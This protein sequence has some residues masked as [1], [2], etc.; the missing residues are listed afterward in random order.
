[1]HHAGAGKEYSNT[2]KPACSNPFYWGVIVH[3]GAIYTT[4]LKISE[5]FGCWGFDLWKH[6][7][8]ARTCLRIRKRKDSIIWGSLKNMPPCCCCWR[9]CW[10]SLWPGALGANDVA[11]AMGASVGAR[12]I[13][14]RQAI[15]IAVIFEFAG[16]YLAGGEVTSTIREGLIDSTK[17]SDQPELL[18]LGCYRLYSLQ[19]SGC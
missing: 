13:T 19:V 1:M 2:I 4:R 9:S 6:L 10:L 16:A 5:F 15:L 11:N 7:Y 3:L 8:N 17:V 14:V 12:S 18:F